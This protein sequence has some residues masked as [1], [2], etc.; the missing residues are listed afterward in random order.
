[1]PALGEEERAQAQA[2]GE[3]VAQAEPGCGE[4]LEAVDLKIRLI[5]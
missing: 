2:D 5:W 4:Q 3:R 1:L